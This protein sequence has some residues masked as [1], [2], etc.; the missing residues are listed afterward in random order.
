MIRIGGTSILVLRRIRL[1]RERVGAAMMPF[2]R[3]VR[4]TVGEDGYFVDAKDREGAGDVA[5]ERGALFMGLSTGTIS[6]RFARW[7]G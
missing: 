2:I 5:G 3:I 7:I 6:L 4:V 1:V